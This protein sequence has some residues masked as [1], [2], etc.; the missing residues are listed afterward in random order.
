MLVLSLLALLLI[1][2]TP[3]GSP[4]GK[5][6]PVGG[7]SLE[8][9]QDDRDEVRA[10]VAHACELSGDAPILCAAYDHIIFRE[11]RGKSSI[12]HTRGEGE[13]GLGPMGLSL[14]WQRK[15]WPGPG[16]PAFCDPVASLAVMRD[17]FWKAF[18][19]Y[20]A[21][22]LV[23][24][25]AVISGRFDCYVLNGKKT[26]LANPR[27]HTAAIMCGEPLR[28]KHGFS[29]HTPLKAS[30]FGPRVK[31]ADRPAWVERMNEAFEAAQ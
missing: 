6:D 24:V 26:C 30:D 23:D 14:K 9:T 12:R 21:E 1:P 13:N 11:S 5:C 18:K 4:I 8:F 7:P 28:K 2:P 31:V 22:D 25:Q 19:V 29:C 16:D 17:I 3:K 10:R 15:R 20:H 27:G